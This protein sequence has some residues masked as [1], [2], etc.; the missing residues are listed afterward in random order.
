[1]VAL[2]GVSLPEK[3]WQRIFDCI[4]LKNQIIH[5]TLVALIATYYTMIPILTVLSVYFLMGI[6]F[7]P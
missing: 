1:M 5:H 3:H 2:V 7:F 4:V 6:K